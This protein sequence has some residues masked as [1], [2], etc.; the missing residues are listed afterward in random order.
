MHAFPLHFCPVRKQYVELDQ[1]RPE[2]A[3]EHG[4][5]LDK[6][7]LPDRFFAASKTDATSTGEDSAPATREQ[8]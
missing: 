4:C 6:C 2:C 1:T 5:A 3:A 8:V 7:C